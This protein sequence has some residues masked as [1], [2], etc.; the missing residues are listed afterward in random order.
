MPLGLLKYGLRRKYPA[1]HHFP[2]PKELKKTY[3]NLVAHL[4]ESEREK[5]ILSI[6]RTM[7]LFKNRQQQQSQSASKGSVKI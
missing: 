2:R 6:S 5:A 7:G 1:Q 3:E 4:P